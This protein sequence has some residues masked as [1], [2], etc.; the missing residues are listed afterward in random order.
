MPNNKL[1]VIRRSHIHQSGPG[2]IIDF[3]AGE[4]GGGPVSVIASAIDFWPN[5]KID[6]TQDPCV[7]RE[8]RL[9]KKLDVGYFRLPPVEISDLNEDDFQPTLKGSRFPSWLLCPKCFSLKHSSKWRKEL[10]DPSRWCGNCSTDDQRVFVV[11]SRF[12]IVCNRGHIDDFPWLWYLKRFSNKAVECN[13]LTNNSENTTTSSEVNDGTDKQVTTSCDLILKS[14]GKTGLS[15]LILSCKKCKASV[16][17][18]SIFNPDTFKDFSCRGNRPWVGDAEP[19]CNGTIK[20]LQRGASNIYFP[21]RISALSIPPWTEDEISSQLGLLWEQFKSITDDVNLRKQIIVRRPPGVLEDWD[22]EE[23]FNYCEEKANY[24]NQPERQDLEKDEYE[25]FTECKEDAN[26]DFQLKNQII[27]SNITRYFEKIIKV[28]RLR[29]V[30]VQTGFSRLLPPVPDENS[31]SN[32]IA[33][34]MKKKHNWLP[35]VEVRGEGIF[36]LL[37]K[38]EIDNWLFNNEEIQKRTFEIKNAYENQCIERNISPA[39]EVNANFILLHTLAHTL[40]Y[41]ISFESGYNAASLKEKIYARFDES[42]RMNGLLLYTGSSDADGTLGGLARQAT[43]DLFFNVFSSA[44]NKARWC[45]QDPLC[46]QG[47]S[48]TSESMNLA[49]CHCCNLLPETSCQFFNRFL[50]RC[51]LVGSPENSKFGFFSK[52]FE[53]KND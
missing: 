30:T 32:N 16:S 7:V 40:L 19:G 14:S 51:F 48:S 10:G 36:I 23:L 3:R 9:E 37:N 29:E 39:I 1:G 46:Y 45:S 26:K 28:E 18:K 25:K 12:V 24:L 38:E 42:S 33:K 34:I 8:E 6:I 4:K 49:A 15:G 35:A 21:D 43:S 2:A 31:T 17:L 44:I 27:N 47:I 13:A 52:F 11:P 50:D 41:Q 22:D 5:P 20:A 53:N